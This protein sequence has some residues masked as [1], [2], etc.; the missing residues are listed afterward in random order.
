MTIPTSLGS[1]W[2]TIQIWSQ[3]IN[4]H[5]VF[6]SARDTNQVIQKFIDNLVKLEQAEERLS[7]LDTLVKRRFE[8]RLDVLRGGS[9]NGIW[10]IWNKDKNTR[11]EVKV[12]GSCLISMFCE[13]VSKVEERFQK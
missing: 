10:I 9:I 7:T 13:A 4:Y 6:D 2:L 12:E 5:L 3:Y 11:E 1:H 8:C